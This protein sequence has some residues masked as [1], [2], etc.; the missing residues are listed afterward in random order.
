MVKVWDWPVRV[1]HW[2]LVLM[3]VSAWLSTFWFG[4]LHQPAGYVALAAVAVRALWGCIGGRYAR[5]T[6]FLRPPAAI[7]AHTR[8]LLQRREPRYIGHNP[9]G[10][11]MILAL[12]ASIAGLA[13]TGWLYTTDRFWGNESI[14]EM[15]QLLAWALLGLVTLHVAGV[16]LTSLRQR[17][18]LVSS[19]I[20]GRKREPGSGDID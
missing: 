17:E 15:H 16:A 13:L 6:Q 2:I 10:G 8:L 20:T 7:V 3:T 1:L 14:E 12:L 5:F 18:N 9:L 4:G 11:W 19:M